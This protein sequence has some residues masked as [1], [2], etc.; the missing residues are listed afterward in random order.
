VTHDSTPD[1]LRHSRR[2]GE[3]VLQLVKDLLDRAVQHDLSKL[4]PPEVDAFDE[5]TPA[6]AV[7][8][9]GSEEYRRHLD[10]MR[11]ALDHHYGHN[12]HHP[13][14]HDA[15]I[16]GMTLVDLVEM[17]ADWKAATERHADGSLTRSLDINRT[18]FGISDQ[19][20]AVLT[21]TAH[22]LG[23]LDDTSVG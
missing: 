13:E 2:V 10:A 7:T 14:H 12:R 1:T 6:L 23:W 9:Y 19:L 18:R 22:A 21:N 16:A 4:E 17:L 5:H 11:P 8:T 20:A 3:L 15:G